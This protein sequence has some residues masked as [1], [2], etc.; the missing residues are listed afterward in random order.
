M[1]TMK[2]DDFLEFLMIVDVF[3]KAESISMNRFLSSYELFFSSSMD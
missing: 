3:D 1:R 2:N